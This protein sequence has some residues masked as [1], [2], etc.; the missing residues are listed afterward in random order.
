MKLD[1]Y[2]VRDLLP[3]YIDKLTSISTNKDIAEHLDNCENCRNKFEILVQ[4][5]EIEQK[6]IE[7]KRE[8]KYLSKYKKKYIRIL[9]T[10]I[11]ILYYVW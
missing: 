1:C 2:I 4:A 10:V 6:I 8:I 9:A 7:N 3:N 5:I 11:I